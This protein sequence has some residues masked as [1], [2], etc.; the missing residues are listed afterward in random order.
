MR[1]VRQQFAVHKGFYDFSVFSFRFSA[2]SGVIAQLGVTFERIVTGIEEQRQRRR[3]RSSMLCV[4]RA[5]K[6]RRVRANGA[7]SPGAG[8]GYYR[9]PER[10]VLEKPRDAEHAAQMLR[11]LR[12]RP[13]R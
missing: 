11:K 9:Y 8:C 1:K 12:V 7:G 5:R 3:A 10:E 2:S 4:W 6:H 13:I